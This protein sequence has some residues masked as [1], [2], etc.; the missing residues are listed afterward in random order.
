MG[1]NPCLVHRQQDGSVNF[2]SFT[3]GSMPPRLLPKA[4]S[5]VFGSSPRARPVFVGAFSRG[6]RTRKASE[7]SLRLN[8]LSAARKNKHGMRSMA[9]WEAAAATCFYALLPGCGNSGVAPGART[10]RTPYKARRPFERGF[11]FS[12]FN[13]H[14]PCN[15]PLCIVFL[16]SCARA[17]TR[18]VFF[19]MHVVFLPLGPRGRVE[20]PCRTCCVHSTRAAAVS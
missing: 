16:I 3:S 4:W 5:P 18:L 19:R 17:W 1:M 6:R 2:A 20:L 15:S 8:H 7:L 9:R 11:V 12:H 13:R 14:A 10:D